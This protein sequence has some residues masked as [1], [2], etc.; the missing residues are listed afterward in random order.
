MKSLNIVKTHSKNRAYLLV[1]PLVFEKRLGA[2]LSIL[3][4]DFSLTVKNKIWNREIKNQSKFRKFV[5]KF[6]SS[7]LNRFN[8][9]F[10]FREKLSF[11]KN[12]FL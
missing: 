2:S 7:A 12:L 1:S 3:N 5:L 9:V 4:L 8:L 6:S 11:S 10:H